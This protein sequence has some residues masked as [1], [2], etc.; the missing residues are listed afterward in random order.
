MKMSLLASKGP[1]P[2]TCELLGR[3]RSWGGS[4]SMDHLFNQK[5]STVTAVTVLTPPPKIGGVT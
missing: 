3:V 1:W 4:L 5:V 2:W